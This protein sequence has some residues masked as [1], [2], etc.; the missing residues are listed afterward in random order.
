[1]DVKISRINQF[2]GCKTENL[3]EDGQKYLLT[4]EQKWGDVL[5][6]ELNKA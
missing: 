3:K 2:S 6:P 1:M 5:D 4:Y